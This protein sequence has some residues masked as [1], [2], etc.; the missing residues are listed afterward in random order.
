MRARRRVSAN[1]RRRESNMQ[2]ARLRTNAN[3]QPSTHERISR[4]LSD[5]LPIDQERNVLSPNLPRDL[6]DRGRIG[7]YRGNLRELHERVALA[8]AIPAQLD[9][10]VRGNAQRIV[11]PRAI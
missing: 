10:S 1:R 6:L 7:L 4:L 11:L 2:E 3:R 8:I 9:P 5:A